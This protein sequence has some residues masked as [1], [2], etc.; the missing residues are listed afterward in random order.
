M[1]H[2]ADVTFFLIIFG[3]IIAGLLVLESIPSQAETYQIITQ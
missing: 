3:I 1:R 2:I